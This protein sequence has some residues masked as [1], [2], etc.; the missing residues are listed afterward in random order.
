MGSKTYRLLLLD[1]RWKEKAG[2]IKKRDNY[3]CQHCGKTGCVL[4]VHHK[5][6]IIGKNPWEIPSRYL[7][8]LCRSCHKKEHS[9]KKISEFFITLEEFRERGKNLKKRKFIKN[10]EKNLEKSKF[11]VLLQSKSKTKNIMKPTNFEKKSVFELKSISDS[12]FEKLKTNLT[13]HENQKMIEK[14]V[15]ENKKMES[16]LEFKRKL[17]NLTLE[18]V[19]KVENIGTENEIHPLQFK[20]AKETIYGLLSW[21]PELN[22]TEHTSRN[23]HGLLSAQMQSGKTG[24]VFALYNIMFIV[25][26][27]DYWEIENFTIMT[28]MDDNNLNHQTKLRSLSQVIGSHEKCNINVWKRIDIKKATL[29]KIKLEKTFIIIDEAHFGSGEFSILNK[30]FKLNNVDWKNTND[31]REKQILIVSISATNFSEIFWDIEGTKRHVILEVDDNYYGCV[32]YIDNGQVFNANK[33]DFNYNSET[34][35]TPIIDII[36][37]EHQRMVNCGKKQG[38][39]LIRVS[40]KKEKKLLEDSFIGENFIT[41][42]LDSRNGKIDMEKL[43]LSV[44]NMILKN[45]QKSLLVIIKGTMRAGITLPEWI[46]DSTTMIYDNNTNPA[47]SNQALFG[48]YCGYR[49]NQELAKFTN[50]YVNRQHILDYATHVQN[51]FSRETVP[52]NPTWKDISELNLNDITRITSKNFNKETDT[53]PSTKF[54][55]TREFSLDKEDVLYLYDTHENFEHGRTKKSDLEE[56]EFLTKGTKNRLKIE[57]LLDKLGVKDVYPYDFMAEPYIW[58]GA[59]NGVRIDGKEIRPNKKGQTRYSNETMKKFINNDKPGGLRTDSHS[60][61]KFI[62]KEKFD[63]TKHLGKKG[64]HIIL[65]DND[66]EN[67][68]L[69][70]VWNEFTQLYRLPNQETIPQKF[71][72]TNLDS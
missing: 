15:E 64:I 31:L 38:L 59:I 39:F 36:R 48:R 17:D 63:I 37:K 26:L 54:V 53:Q 5:N 2:Y 43:Y 23:R 8:T 21:F 62:Y 41:L 50:C 69:R 19:Q 20:A 40:T 6:Y 3:T 61:F 27:L 46:K 18:Q 1:E 57:K 33:F 47:S 67:L 66:I 72:S 52:S 35:S 56:N 51:D 55:L 4:D 9:N 12:D 28:G 34:K 7:V 45:D 70:I 14:L 44:E 71:K 49:K 29:N 16:N 68:R 42:P 25:G 65:L 11:D 22:E 32:K 60:H 24:Y 58:P 13:I 30:F 10:D